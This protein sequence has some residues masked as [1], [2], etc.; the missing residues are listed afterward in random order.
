MPDLNTI[1][2]LYEVCVYTHVDRHAY[3]PFLWLPKELSKYVK[4][5]YAKTIR[6]IMWQM[7][8]SVGPPVLQQ[9]TL[10]PE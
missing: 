8:P 5:H 1:F 10:E 3:D 7:P 2:Y 6:R 4:Q 9:L